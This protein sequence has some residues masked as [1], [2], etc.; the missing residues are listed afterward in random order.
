MRVAAGAI[1]KKYLAQHGVKTSGYVSQIGSIAADSISPESAN[2]NKY[3]FVMSKI[4]DLDK[5]FKS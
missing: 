5:M 2:Q 1:A 3:F 4:D